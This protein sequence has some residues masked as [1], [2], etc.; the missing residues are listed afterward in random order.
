LIYG[1]NSRSS[2]KLRSNRGCDLR[3]CAAGRLLPNVVMPVAMMPVTAIFVRMRGT[4]KRHRHA[5]P[6]NCWIVPL[7]ASKSMRRSVLMVSDRAHETRHKTNIVA[8]IDTGIGIY[9]R[10]CGY[11]VNVGVRQILRRGGP[12]IDDLP[13]GVEMVVC[14]VIDEN[15]RDRTDA[16]LRRIEGEE[17]GIILLRCY[18]D[19]VGGRMTNVARIV[20]TDPAWQ[21]RSVQ[22]RLLA[23]VIRMVAHF[24]PPDFAWRGWDN[25]RQSSG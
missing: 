4:A 7:L 12:S 22:L 6:K 9:A 15:A 19:P 24:F 2:D 10:G 20:I 3:R 5:A 25:S 23:A 1:S 11:R 8:K 16:V 14:L 17:R 18:T 21:C 13:R